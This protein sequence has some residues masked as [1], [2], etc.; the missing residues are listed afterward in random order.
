MDV[1]VTK[2]WNDN[3]NKD[4]NRPDSVTVRLYA[5]GVEVASQALTAGA[6]WSH[7]FTELPR[8]K[9]DNKTEIVYSVNEDAVPMYTA[10]I[11]GYNLVNHYLPEK[12]SSTVVKVWQDNN[13]ASKHRPESI[14]MTLFVTAGGEE[15]KVKAVTLNDANN[16]TETVNDLPTVV[17]GVKA[18][19]TWKEQQVLGERRAGPGY[20]QGQHED[21]Q[22]GYRRD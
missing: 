20:A 22:G 6:G 10:E 4:G 2:T 14:V 13:N 3:N 1:P 7:T 19:Y 15:T 21:P 12:T 17:N 16:W 5:D 9:E 8:Y 11:N 18:Q